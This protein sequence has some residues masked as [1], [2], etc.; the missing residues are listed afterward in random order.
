MLIG[1]WTAKRK[2]KNNYREET[3]PFTERLLNP[4]DT[5]R[6]LHNHANTIKKYDAQTRNTGKPRLY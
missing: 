6:S 2:N 5:V 1:R 3:L 4:R